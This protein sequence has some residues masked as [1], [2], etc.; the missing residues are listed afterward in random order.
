MTGTMTRS[1]LVMPTLFLLVACATVAHAQ[2]PPPNIVI[3][4]A[5]DAG[6]MDF[7][8]T[9][10]SDLKTP[11]IDQLAS[12]SVVCTQGYVT[13]S[14]CSPSRAGLLTGR[15]QQRFG[16]EFNLRSKSVGLPLSEK[17]LADRLGALGYRSSVIGKWHLGSSD[18]MHPLSRGFDEFRGFL[19]GSRPYFPRA[20]ETPGERSLMRDRE[21]IAEASSAYVTDWMA[22]EAATFIHSNRE[23]PFFLY[24]AFNAVHTPMQAKPEDL[25]IFP[26]IL[27]SKRQKL[28]GMTIALDRAV[29]HIMDTLKNEGLD[30]RTI[31]FFLN[32]NGGATTNASDNGPLRGMKGSKWE[33]GIR[34]PYVVRW[35]D[36]LP[37]GN[38]YDLPVSTLDIAA[39]A[40]AVAGAGTDSMSDLDGVDLLPHLSGKEPDTPH[41]ILFWRRGPAAAVRVGKWKLL[42]IETNPVLLMDLDADLGET[43]NLAAQEPEIVEQLLDRLSEWEAGLVNPLWVTD[44]KWQD[45]QIRKHRMDVI[46]RPAERAIP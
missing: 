42:R 41:E 6:Y 4:F 3:L 5:D 26:D 27:D 8:F 1:L 15:Y 23:R 38:H 21:V 28:A 7:G 30:R 9:G 40:L 13:A 43:T 22:Q 32:D 17:T 18:E 34:V 12:E 35:S 45:N 2:E 24:V 33:G 46:G 19:T 25:A 14:V 39:T 10:S 16:H 36:H 31:I 11:R 29:G 44:E 20:K 37:A